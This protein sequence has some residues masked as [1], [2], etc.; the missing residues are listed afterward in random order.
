MAEFGS[1]NSTVF[2]AKLVKSL[3]SY[4]PDLGFI[5]YLR[6]THNY[7]GEIIH[8]DHRYGGQPENFDKDIIF[9]DGLDRD[10]LLA[11]LLGRLKKE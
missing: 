2:F 6:D 9:I 1:G 4:E 5:T 10:A 11:T 8:V 7:Q 3:V